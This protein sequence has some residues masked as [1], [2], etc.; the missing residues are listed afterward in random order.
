MGGGRNGGIE[1]GRL[2]EIA[3]QRNRLQA[4][5]HIVEK[6]SMLMLWI[7]ILVVISIVLS[8]KGP[9]LE[10]KGLLHLVR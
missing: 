10:L 3:G 9:C 4:R 6:H 1:A 5:L 8:G 2:G 7:Y